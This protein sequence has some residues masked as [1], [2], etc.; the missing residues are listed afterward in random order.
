MMLSRPQS[1]KLASAATIL[2]LLLT[3]AGCASDGKK[4]HGEQQKDAARKQWAGARA[5][6]L[7]NLASEQYQTGN[8]DKCRATLDDALKLAPDN[9]ALHLLYAKLCIEQGN[10][11]IADRELATVRLLAPENAEADYLSGVISQRWQ[12]NEQAFSFYKSAAD[13]APAELAYLM[14]QG[15]MLVTMGRPAEALAML[16]SR[17]VY[18]EHSAAL[19]DAVGQLLMQNAKYRQAVAMFRQASIL[20]TDDPAIREHLAIAQFR[21]GDHRDAADTLKRLLKDDRYLKRGDLYLALGVCELQLS[22]HREAREAF[23]MASQ[24]SPTSSAVWLGLGK[25]AMELSD[26]R[27]AEIALRR[28]LTLEPANSEANLLLG[29]AR[30]KQNKLDDA[31]ASFRKANALNPADT[32]ALC[33]VGHTLEKLGRNAEAFECYQKALKIRPDDDL[34]AKLMADIQLDK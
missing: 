23:E 4:P 25:A 9:P 30:L 26:T 19:R 2:G 27:R 12:K 8:F 29:Y 31:L 34:A 21:A 15:E 28:C 24:L 17:V 10:L 3:L 11:E 16:E 6:V 18:F 14:A 1:S 5:A 33:M 32:T 13:K 20:S 7:H 22:R